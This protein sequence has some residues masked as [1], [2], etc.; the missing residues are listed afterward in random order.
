MKNPIPFLCA[1]QLRR[2]M[3]VFGCWLFAFSA[4]AQPIT[5]VLKLTPA[6]LGSFAEELR[7]N[8]PALKAAEARRT[9]AEART[10]GVRSWADPEVSIATSLTSRMRR[11][12]DGDLVYGV[13]QA[14]P[15]W[16]RPAAERRASEAATRTAG[17]EWDYRFQQL[18]L[19]LVRQF[20][21]TALADRAAAI[22][23]EDLTWLD[24]LV[25]LT[26]QRVATGDSSA[27]AVLRLENERD[28]QQTKLA[29][30]KELGRQACAE[31]N[32][33]LGRTNT[34]TWP[35]LEL[36]DLGPEVRF[37]DRFR[38]LTLRNEAKLKLLRREA[39]ASESGIDLAKRATRPDVKVFG[40][41]RQYSGNGEAREGMV[42][43]ALSVPWFNRSR[44]RADIARAEA[45]ADAA[46]LDAADYERF[47][48]VEAQRVATL[49]GN[50][51]R[52][53]IAY[54]DRILPRTTEM[55]EATR[56]NWLSGR[57]ELMALFDIRRQR[58]EAQRMLANATAEQWQMLAEITLCCGLADLEAI[59]ALN[60]PEPDAGIQKPDTGSKP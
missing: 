36:P 54:R 45:E 11:E 9:A 25:D 7:T 30:E 56:G 18:R 37:N 33:L 15:L 49:A 28:L 23:A 40:E 53:A 52:E 51:R 1:D 24:S 29:S 19:E 4:S 48:P 59:E 21:R 5:N 3:L 39:E 22:T 27:A 41:L 20:F 16:G 42:G 10:A 55:L 34:A 57:A 13:S 17:A 58:L 50:A 60:G 6:V 44:Y 43:V 14:L 2:S 31:L 38:Q 26:R 47:V 46:R 8:S 35:K 32:R 12:D